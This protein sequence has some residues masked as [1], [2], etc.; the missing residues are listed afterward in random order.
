MVRDLEQELPKLQ[1][2][3]ANILSRAA[4][5]CRVGGR[6]LYA[7]CSVLQEEAEE[8]IALASS[9]GTKLRPAPF[10]GHELRKLAEGSS[11]IRLLPQ[12]HGTDGYFMAS[13]ERIE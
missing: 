1:L 11:H 7:V 2:L 12:E 6:V 8:A 5:R 3:Q 13:L 9:M 4:S 10:E